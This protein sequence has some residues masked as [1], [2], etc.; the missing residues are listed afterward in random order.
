[1]AR[2]ELLR[3]K[4][5]RP[6]RGRHW[7]LARVYLGPQG[8]GP[9]CGRGKPN[10]VWDVRRNE[11]AFL[12]KDRQRVPVATREEFVGR[13]RA[14]QAVLRAFRNGQAEVLI[15][16]MGALGIEPCRAAVNLR[17]AVEQTGPDNTARRPTWRE[18]VK[19]NTTALALQSWL[20]GPYTRDPC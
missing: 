11:R 7:H 1:M 12:D 18:Q 13:R 5:V 8:G 15:H 3:E 19:T 20:S 16:G 4:V 17:C 9:L 2:R 6:E 10:R 14:I